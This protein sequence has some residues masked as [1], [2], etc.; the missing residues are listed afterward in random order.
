MAIGCVEG[1]WI[2]D[3]R[4]PQCKSPAYVRLVGL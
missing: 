4:D 1:L 3:I 2:G